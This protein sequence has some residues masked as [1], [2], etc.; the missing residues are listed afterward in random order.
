MLL[1]CLFICLWGTM[2]CSLYQPK[3]ILKSKERSTFK[4]V[5]CSCTGIALSSVAAILLLVVSEAT[6]FEECILLIVSDG[7]T[8]R[9]KPQS[10]RQCARLANED[11]TEFRNLEVWE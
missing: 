1:F 11:K 2:I 9:T 10:H 8:R 6:L 5:S 3:D 7:C 4:L